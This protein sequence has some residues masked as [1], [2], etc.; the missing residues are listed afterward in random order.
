VVDVAG[1]ELREPVSLPGEYVRAFPDGVRLAFT[2]GPARAF[3]DY[4]DFATF[5]ASV[6]IAE[7][8]RPG[9][10][11]LVPPRDGIGFG[12]FDVSADGRS[13]AVRAWRADGGE[14]LLLV[15]TTTGRW[16]TLARAD[17]VSQPSW[18]PAERMIAVGLSDLD[19]SGSLVTIDASTGEQR[20]LA[21]GEL[22]DRPAWSPDGT[23]IAFATLERSEGEQAPMRLQVVDVDHPDRVT[24]VVSAPYITDLDW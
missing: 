13:L 14:A 10:R 9:S 22:P 23:R 5:R 15:D 18:S 20:T 12:P 17:R 19:G 21:A 16:R 11:L 8:G 24:T 3:V 2:S 1:G 7:I 6:R 4:V